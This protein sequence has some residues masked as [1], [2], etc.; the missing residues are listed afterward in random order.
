MFKIDF[1]FKKIVT[2]K[3]TDSLGMKMNMARKE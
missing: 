3:N 2:K 1:L